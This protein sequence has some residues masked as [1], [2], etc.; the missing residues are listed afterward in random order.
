M[1][2]LL[3]PGADPPAAGDKTEGMEGCGYPASEREKQAGR[4]SG[5]H[6]RQA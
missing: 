3:K 1:K 2:I 4:T 5:H 6:Y